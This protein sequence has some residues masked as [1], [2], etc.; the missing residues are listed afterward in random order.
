MEYRILLKNGE[1]CQVPLLVF[2]KRY[3]RP[4]SLVSVIQLFQVVLRGGVQV[5]FSG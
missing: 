5:L 2:V 1:V 3:K 4:V